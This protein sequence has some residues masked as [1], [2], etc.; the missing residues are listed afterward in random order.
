VGNLLVEKFEVGF[1]GLD[2]LENLLSHPLESFILFLLTVLVNF[3][4]NLFSRIITLVNKGS[5]VLSQSFL[6]QELEILVLVNEVSGG[7]FNLSEV[8]S[9]DLEITKKI[10]LILDFNQVVTVAGIET[11]HLDGE[12]DEVI[13]Y[14][15]DDITNTVSTL[16]RLNGRLELDIT[17]SEVN[18]DIKHWWK[19]IVLVVLDANLVREKIH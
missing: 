18:L 12:R 14:L 11:H 1:L 5:K 9:H 13:G 15:H 16:A 17:V 2:T 7:I 10:K 4:V 3:H 8:V 19:L 6:P